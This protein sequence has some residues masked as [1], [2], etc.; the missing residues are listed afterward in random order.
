MSIY[1]L[2]W[3]ER[4]SLIPEGYLQRVWF[5]S[6]SRSPTRLRMGVKANVAFLLQEHVL[7]SCT[8]QQKRDITLV[9]SGRRINRVCEYNQ[10][11]KPWLKAKVRKYQ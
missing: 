9:D 7:A 4:P 5:K 2:P 6:N 10:R 8:S 3:E 11:L 1:F